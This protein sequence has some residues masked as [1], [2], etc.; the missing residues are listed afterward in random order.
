MG[1]LK[2]ITS[3][4]SDHLFCSSNA[5]QENLCLFPIQFISNERNQIDRRQL[6]P[7]ESDR[8]PPGRE[9]RRKGGMLRGEDIQSNPI[10]KRKSLR[11]EA[12]GLKCRHAESEWM[13]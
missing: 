4:L 12:G 2:D 7:K 8:I 3:L 13:G 9:G 1:L 5:T 11:V 6:G 10:F